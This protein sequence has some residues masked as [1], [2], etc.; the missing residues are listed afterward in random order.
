[1]SCSSRTSC[2]YATIMLCFFFLRIRRPPRSTRTDTLFPDTTLFR[3]RE[4]GVGDGFTV[5][6]N[7][8]GEPSGSCS[9]ANVADIP[10]DEA[11]LPL[12]QLVGI[13]AFERARSYSGIRAFEKSQPRLTD[14]QR[15]CLLWVGRGKRDRKSTRLNSSH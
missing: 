9:F 11:T 6:A 13:F 5:P 2:S 15:D 4:Y 10:V 1:M 3:S 14:R 12:A 7:V 8:P